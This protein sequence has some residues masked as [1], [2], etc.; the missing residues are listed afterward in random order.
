MS[1][2]T[3]WDEIEANIR[4]LEAARFAP[5]PATREEY[6]N[7]IRKGI[8][9]L[10]YTSETGIA[11]APSKF[12]GYINN[13]FAEH[14]RYRN[15]K[16]PNNPRHGGK[17]NEAIEKIVGT[18]PKDDPEAEQLYQDFWHQLTFE[19][20]SKGT[21]GNKRKYWRLESLI[22]ISNSDKTPATSQRETTS[23]AGSGDINIPEAVDAD[24]AVLAAIVE[25]DAITA[26]EKE[27]L[28]K[29]RVGQGGFRTNLLLLHKKTCC[30][31]G[32]KVTEILRASHIKPWSQSDNRERLDPYNG[33]LLTPNID[34]LFD[35]G[36]IT[37][38]DEGELLVSD[39]LPVDAKK[40]LLSNCKGHIQIRSNNLPYLD[41]HRK[42]C[43][44]HPGQ[45]L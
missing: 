13:T 16:D 21:A 15:N 1:T 29:A 38:S 10:T 34:A 28:I 24:D 19:P 20:K 37:F 44:Q 23:P 33:L 35:Q 41:Y 6:I 45:P 31:T 27:Q 39:S 14:I 40:L 30:V 36:F 11:F 3:T 18:K 17:T 26:T 32:C 42:K 2:V 8:C 9:F 4:T 7:F 22:D 43:F 25:D 5:D 12:V